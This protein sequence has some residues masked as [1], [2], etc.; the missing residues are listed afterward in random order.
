[1]VE[2]PG[3]QNIVP[4]SPLSEAGG[5]TFLP[6]NQRDTNQSWSSVRS[7]MCKKVD[8]AYLSYI[9]QK[10]EPEIFPPLLFLMA[11]KFVVALLCKCFTS[12]SPNNE[13]SSL[14]VMHLNSHIKS[15]CAKC[16]RAYETRSH[17][18]HMNQVGSAN[19]SWIWVFISTLL[20]SRD[21]GEILNVPSCDT[22]SGSFS[23]AWQLPCEQGWT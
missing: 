17:V 5:L 18:E 4:L 12:T 9:L 22:L 13:S 14:Q 21:G 15:A 7:C 20:L 10:Q 3:Q 8:N 16:S 23:W 1:M 19:P 2:R 11:L 6:V